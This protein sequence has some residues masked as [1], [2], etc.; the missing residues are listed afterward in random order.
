MVYIAYENM[1]HIIYHREKMQIKTTVRDFLGGPV[2]HAST[3]GGVGLI[4][5]CG[6]EILHATQH[7]QKINKSLKKQ[8][9]KIK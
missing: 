4:P 3:A 6:T 1:L 7:G 2:V 5:D 8:K 9:I